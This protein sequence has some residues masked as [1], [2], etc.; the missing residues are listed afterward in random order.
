M[1][2]ATPV[3][4]SR[5]GISIVCGAPDVVLDGDRDLADRPLVGSNPRAL[6]ASKIGLRTSSA[7][8]TV[9]LAMISMASITS[10]LYHGAMPAGRVTCGQPGELATRTGDAALSG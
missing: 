8:F 7:C 6:R 9:T 2:A 4:V 5:C 10:T 3:G 1:S